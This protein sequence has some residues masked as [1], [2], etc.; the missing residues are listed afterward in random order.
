MILDTLILRADGSQIFAAREYP[1]PPA[2]D[3]T[4]EPENEGSPEETPGKNTA[5]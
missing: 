4:P 1:D 2:R 5:E 3:V